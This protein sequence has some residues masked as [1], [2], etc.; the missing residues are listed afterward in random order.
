MQRM[1]RIAFLRNSLAVFTAIA[2]AGSAFAYFDESYAQA[3]NEAD[4][5]RLDVIYVPTPHEVVK[6]MLEIAKVG[7]NDIHYDLGSGDGRIVI[8][9]VKDF[10]AR[11]GVGIDLDPK[12][13]KEAQDNLAKAG[14]G[15]RVTF[16]NQNIFE[17]D[18]SEASVISLYL[19]STLNL[20]LRPTLLD[21]KPGTRIVTQSFA[22][23]NWEP[24]YKESVEFDATGYKGART[25]YLFVVPAKVGGK[26]AMNAGERNIALDLSQ[27]FQHFKGT[28]TVDGKNTTIT[29]G[30]LNGANIEFTLEIDGKPLK[31][32]G[33]VEGNG[34]TGNNWAAKKA[35]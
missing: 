5:P 2:L 26:W 8:S 14:V 22:M 12:R 27:A 7:P 13:I 19:L 9:A 18:F 24:D 15:D 20:K 10:K 29:D 11:K 3:S 6:R 32:E 17:T 34:I 23:D 25:V 31:Y 35:S 21:M 33:K 30:K 1:T 4:D 16:L 28:A